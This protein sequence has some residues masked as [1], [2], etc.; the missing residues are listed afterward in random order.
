MS[1]LLHATIRR[2]LPSIWKL[3]ISPAFS[4]G[5]RAECWFC[6]R[7]RRAWAV[8]H[9]ADR[10]DVP[11][12]EVVVFRV[13]VPRSRLVAPPRGVD[14]RHGRQVHPLRQRPRRP[15]RLSRSQLPPARCA[16]GPSLVSKDQQMNPRTC[17]LRIFITNDQGLTSYYRLKPLR[18]AELGQSVAAFKVVNSCKD[19]SP[20]Y[21]V[22]L[23][24][25]G[26]ASCNCPAT[27]LRRQVQ[28]RRRPARR[29]RV[30]RRPRRPA[31][32]AD[33]VARQG[34]GGPGRGVRPAPAAAKR[35]G[36]A[37]PARPQ[38][39]RSPKSLAA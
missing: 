19:P 17:D 15:G 27:Q 28:A 29:R 18:G 20:V 13:S 24:I 33:P 2:N 34:R 5:A 16:G 31:A 21:V 26:Q 35:P 12:S 10:H 6:T 32:R 25:D 11:L 8:Q 9:V 39:R 37:P 30:A 7:S 23:A 36:G 4:Q 1:I 22:R 14:L 38:R 3:G